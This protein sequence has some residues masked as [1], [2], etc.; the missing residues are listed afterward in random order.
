M[1]KILRIAAS[2]A[3]GLVALSLFCSNPTDQS[4]RWRSKID[5][6]V[7]NQKFFIKQMMHD[8]FTLPDSAKFLGSDDTTKLVDTL[9]YATLQSDTIQ[10]KYKADSLGDKVYNNVLGPIPLSG[11]AP[12]SM[13]IISPG[14][15]PAGTSRVP[16]QDSLIL[17]GVNQ[18]VFDSSS[19]PLKV[20]IT[21]QTANPMDSV[22]IQFGNLWDIPA[23]YWD[24]STFV[25]TINAGETKT[26]PYTV[27]NH[28][29]L[30]GQFNFKFVG[31]VT[32][33]VALGDPLVKCKVSFDSLTASAAIIKDSLF[34]IYKVFSNSYKITDSVNLDYVDIGIQGQFVYTMQNGTGLNFDV[35]AVHQDLWYT[36]YCE[37]QTPPIRTDS[38]L[39]LHTQ[40][41]TLLDTN[42][43]SGYG[44]RIGHFQ[45]K[46]HQSLGNDTDLAPLNVA[47]M[48]IFPTWGYATPTATVPTSNTTV[49]Y[50]LRSMP[51]RGAWDTL[52]AGAQIVFTVSSGDIKFDK[53]TGTVVHEFR[54]DSDTTKKKIPF[55]WNDAA[56]DSLRGK[57]HLSSV[58]AAIKINVDVPD[59][60]LIDTFIVKLTM[61]DIAHPAT[62][63]T[64]ELVLKK[65]RRGVIFTDTLNITDVV[66][67][68][69]DSVTMFIN[70]RVPVGTHLKI[71]NN[72]LSDGNTGAMILN[73]NVDYDMIA[74]LD[75]T[76]Y[77]DVSLD[78]G[79]GKFKV[80][81]AI[82]T[83]DKLQQMTA[84]FN[85]NLT[86]NTNIY[87]T[88]YALLDPQK[89]RRQLL[90]SMTT[91]KFYALV[92]FPDTAEAH[93]YINLLSP[94]GT[95]LPD[96]S[97]DSVQFNSI[98]IKPAQLDL[99]MNTDSC[100][101]RWVMKFHTNPRDAMRNN[102]YAKIDS[103][104]TVEGV[105][106]MDSLASFMKKK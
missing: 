72:F 70:G 17:S 55:L 2:L 20:T 96:R 14:A 62:L 45:I 63:A 47:G 36:S 74:K 34:S 37:R 1:K 31:K 59:S 15:L 56:K 22:W 89:G 38:L 86:N 88:L 93:G 7:S 83:F 100:Y 32:G 46:P 24:D 11:I 102:D 52:D 104:I 71:V 101:M 8:M 21:N 43:S 30:S 35:R 98:S 33:P 73:G 51:P 49:Y 57:F 94:L 39:A 50:Y 3:P 61:F 19:A 41:W 60:A 95:V 75:W 80:D 10:M 25:G 78:M 105:N 4:L 87:G 13:Q 91:E 48:R 64:K 18:I 12:D 106:T 69:P 44:G 40:G 99:L 97:I 67:F 5:M 66:N 103:W 90:D 6:P 54:K 58:F 9:A 29:A 77:S 28:R 68:F 82:K 53:M 27:A 81:E 26:V 16:V 65:V 79:S 76:V 42:R 92:S 85:M 84:S 23:G